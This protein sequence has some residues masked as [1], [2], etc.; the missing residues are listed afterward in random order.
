[1]ERQPEGIEVELVGGRRVR[2]ARDMGPDAICA[3][4]DLLERTT[5]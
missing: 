4:I 5:P 3:M 1:V 2:F